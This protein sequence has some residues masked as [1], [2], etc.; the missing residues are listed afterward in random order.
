MPV[1]HDRWR[2]WK[3]DADRHDTFFN[4][5]SANTRSNYFGSLQCDWMSFHCLLIKK[6]WQKSSSISQTSRFSLVMDK[7]FRN[8]KRSTDK[9][10][11][12]SWNSRNTIEMDILIQSY[13][14]YLIFYSDGI[15]TVSGDHILCANFLLFSIGQTSFDRFWFRNI[16]IY[17]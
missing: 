9:F 12:F 13:A 2:R 15:Q 11:S 10:A 6:K 3:R 5:L 17:A 14:A 4:Y 1:T 16:P 7:V 8:V